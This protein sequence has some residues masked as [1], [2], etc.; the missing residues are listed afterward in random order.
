MVFSPL[1]S[2]A[3]PLVPLAQRPPRQQVAARLML[4]MEVSLWP[5]LE[6]GAPHPLA[7]L[8]AAQPFGL[9]WFAQ[10]LQ[11]HAAG[12]TGAAQL[13]QRMAQLQALHGGASPCLM[14]LDQEG[15]RVE[16]LPQ[17]LGG[18]FASPRVV[19]ALA[20]Q[21]PA[22][23][24]QHHRLLAQTVAALGFH[25]NFTPLLDLDLNPAN[26]I[27]GVRALGEE[28][29][30]VWPLAQGVLQAHHVAGV[31]PVVKHVPG[32]GTGWE[33]SHEAL[34]TLLVHAEEQALFRQAF[35]SGLAP[36][37]MAA[38]GYYPSLLPSGAP[39][40]PA[41]LSP[42]VLQGHVRGTLGFEGVLLSD[43]MNMGAL[44]AF[45][46]PLEVAI[47]ALNAGCDV[48][49]YRYGHEGMLALFEALVAALEAGAL[50][51]AQ[52]EASLRRL[53]AFWQGNTPLPTVP[54]TAPEEG[55][56]CMEAFWAQQSATKATLVEEGVAALLA[57][58]LAQ[59][60]ALNRHQP[61]W[62]LCP[63]PAACPPYASALAGGVEEGPSLVALLAQQS[64]VG[65]R[66]SGLR[67]HAADDTA[68][69]LR[70]CEDVKRDPALQVVVVTYLPQV[71]GP[72]LQ[73]VHQQLS[74][75]QQAQVRVLAFGALGQL[76]GEAAQAKPLATVA[77]GGLRAPW[78][79]ALAR[80]WYTP[81]L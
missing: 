74:P 2:A 47:A 28:A 29:S 38:H 36:L 10:H 17:G 75:A 39:P 76:Q 51:A 43:D 35:A 52:H 60:S 31:C 11:G 19:A 49:L 5:A 15:G 55:Q 65:V 26:P 73:A 12:A 1:S 23:V 8:L 27:I 4:G 79:A 32:H 80:Q 77:L 63:T 46:S 50:D 71:G 69:A 59:G 7:T 18:G 41:T 33:D 22:W 72:V 13:H 66:S 24:A 67:G 61:L 58:P 81:S 37:A 16:R 25:I 14:A 21:H 34:P 62:V 44:D 45:G 42:A 30:V 9:I 64:R 6:A 40:L 3:K 54:P 78:V 57:A 56:Q 53:D 70:L 20:P 48:L 68:L